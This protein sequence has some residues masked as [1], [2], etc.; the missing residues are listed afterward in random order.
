MSVMLSD[1][2][3]TRI[4]AELQRVLENWEKAGVT[5][6]MQMSISRMCTKAVVRVLE[7]EEKHPF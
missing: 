3:K 4:E 7:D 1:H 5:V 2:L 6:A